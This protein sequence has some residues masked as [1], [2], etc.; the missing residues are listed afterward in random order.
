VYHY[1]GWGGIV[2]REGIGGEDLLGKGMRGRA[3]QSEGLRIRRGTSLNYGRRPRKEERS[4]IAGG[5]KEEN[6]GMPWPSGVRGE[7]RKR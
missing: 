4:S 1:F 6:I 2:K 3:T 7:G 5:K